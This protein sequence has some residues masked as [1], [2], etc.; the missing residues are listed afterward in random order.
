MDRPEP[1]GL[2]EQIDIFKRNGFAAGIGSLG[3]FVPAFGWYHAHV[4]LAG[5]EWWDWWRKPIAYVMVACLAY[6]VLSVWHFGEKFGDPIKA[7]SLV[8]A[9]EGTMIWADT[10]VG[11]VALLLLIGINAVTTTCQ[12]IAVDKKRGNALVASLERAN[13]PSP[14][15]APEPAKRLRKQAVPA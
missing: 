1:M 8:I 10:L 4:T 6:S 12:L 7:A 13:R 9:L 3:G 14:S 2:L 5:I 15:A 11:V